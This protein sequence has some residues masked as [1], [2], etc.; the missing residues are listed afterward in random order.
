M[1]C[2]RRS[3]PASRGEGEAEKNEEGEEVNQMELYP[4]SGLMVIHS[5]GL[6]D[7]EQGQEIKR[8]GETGLGKT[9]QT[10]GPE[11]K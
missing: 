10:V 8:K 6:S 3:E 7:K 11:I 5:N 2:V 1:E 4:Q 9:Q